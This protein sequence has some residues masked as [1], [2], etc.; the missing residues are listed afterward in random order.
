M[1]SRFEGCVVIVILSPFW[2]RSWTLPWIKFRVYRIQG[3]TISAWHFYHFPLCD[4]V[5][6]WGR[7][8]WGQYIQLFPLPF[9]VR[10][11]WRRSPFRSRDCVTIL[12]LSLRATGGSVAISLFSIRHEIAS[13]VSLPRN[14]IPTQS[15]R[16]EKCS[17][18]TGETPVLHETPVLP[19]LFY[20]WHLYPN[21][22]KT[23]PFMEM[24]PWWWTHWSACWDLC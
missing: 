23:N 13:V 1:P 3:L 8:R 11:G 9:I 14:D 18:R 19:I 21:W 7:A 6:R 15:P 22:A 2:T 16:E 4:T 12:F 10:L 17:D 20:Y 24:F 5:S